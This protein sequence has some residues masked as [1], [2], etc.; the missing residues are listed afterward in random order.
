MR[1]PSIVILLC[2]AWCGCLVFLLGPLLLGGVSDGKKKIVRLRCDDFQARGHKIIQNLEGWHSGRS[3]AVRRG[4]VSRGEGGRVARLH[5]H[6]VPSPRWDVS[7]AIRSA[8]LKN[9]PPGALG[10]RFSQ[11][12]F[13]VR[14]PISTRTPDIPRSATVAEGRGNRISFSRSEGR[15]GAGTEARK[16]VELL[17]KYAQGKDRITDRA[18]RVHSL[19]LL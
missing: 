19:S 17:G 8:P 15:G 1:G 13:D 18:S 2:G 3:L 14:P 6:A 16:S 9:P 4:R 5:G 7:G 10:G 11:Y 12:D